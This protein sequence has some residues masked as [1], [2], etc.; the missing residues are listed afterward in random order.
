VADAEECK[1]VAD[2]TLA[3]VADQLAFLEGE[4]ITEEGRAQAVGVNMDRRLSEDIRVA[5]DGRGIRP[6]RSQVQDMRLAAVDAIL[7]AAGVKVG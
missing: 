3:A 5:T 2:T 4:Q 1:D 7:T 6:S